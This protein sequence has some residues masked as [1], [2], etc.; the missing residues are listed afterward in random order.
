MPPRVQLHVGGGLGA[1]PADRA[2]ASS[3]FS[4]SRTMPGCTTHV[5]PSTSTDSS[6]AQCFDQSMTTAVLAHCPARLGAA[7]P[8]RTGAPKSRAQ[9]RP[10]RP[11]RRG[12]G[13]TTTPMGTWR[14]LEASVGVGARL[15]ASNRPRRPPRSR[16]A[17]LPGRRCPGR[18]RGQQHQQWSRQPVPPVMGPMTGN[19][20][21]SFCCNVDQSMNTTVVRP[22][23]IT[24]S[25]R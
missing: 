24:R 16:R 14:K 15:P 3:R 25:S 19:A 9:R 4:S 10:P 2:P 6:S 17:V 23:R 8:D 7:A 18:R 12:C 13:A 11:P 1:V 20:L 5:R 21:L 22:F